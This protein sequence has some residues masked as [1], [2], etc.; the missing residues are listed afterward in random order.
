MKTSEKIFFAFVGLS[1]FIAAALQFSIVADIN[2]NCEWKSDQMSSDI[3]VSPWLGGFSLLGSF[4]GNGVW[5]YALKNNHSTLRRISLL[6]WCIILLV[7]VVAVGST[8]GQI[9]LYSLACP[10]YESNL[11]LNAIQY[12]SLSLL[13]FAISAPHA[14]NKNKKGKE[15]PKNGEGAGA[16]L[17]SKVP[18]DATKET[19]PLVFL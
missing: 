11:N 1:I 10:N 15:E 19:S 4:I 3:R 13:I 7:G 18:S 17:V 8:L 5:L 14:L 16:P 2:S 6:L 12:I 9:P